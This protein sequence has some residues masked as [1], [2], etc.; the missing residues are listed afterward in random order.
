MGHDDA[1]RNGAGSGSGLDP[2]P[3]HEQNESNNGDECYRQ[4]LLRR[5]VLHGGIL[6]Q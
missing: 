1:H 6:T 5:P 4:E 3:D 2:Q